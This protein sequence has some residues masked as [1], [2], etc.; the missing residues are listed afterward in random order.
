MMIVPIYYVST[1]KYLITN[2]QINGPSKIKNTFTM[3]EPPELPPPIPHE[4]DAV[5]LETETTHRSVSELMALINSADAVGDPNLR[6]AALISALRTIREELDIAERESEQAKARVNSAQDAFNM[7][8]VTLAGGV[9]VPVESSAVHV[10][11]TMQDVHVTY[12]KSPVR[13][14]KSRI[15]P[16]TYENSLDE[17]LPDN[18]IVMPQT[19]SAGGGLTEEQ[20]GAHREAFYKQLLG[21]PFSQVENYVPNEKQPNLRSKAQLVEGMHI[22]ENW[23]TGADGMDVGTFRSKHKTWYTRMKPN[24]T[25]L[26]R[27]TGIHVR[28]LS[29]PDPT[30]GIQNYEE[31]TVLCRYNKDGTKSIVYLDVGKVFDAL[32]EI[33]SVEN[34][35]KGKDVVK[36][37][38]DELYANIP[39]GQVR[40]FIETCPICA[41]KRES[42]IRILG[43]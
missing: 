15:A 11:V 23:Y 10:D 4:Q 9:H 21:I 13:D 34:D 33:H 6:D 40:T 28:S 30:S 26:G 32:F 43:S 2:N 24:S 37:R 42:S 3:L 5:E 8:S 31:G 12:S 27:R 25:N 36:A 20:I 18:P 19:Y 14:G 39:D 29:P 22:V 1:N 7:A 16:K 38:V 35:H 41:A 17:P